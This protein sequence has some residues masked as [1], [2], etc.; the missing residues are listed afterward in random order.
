MNDLSLQG[1]CQ[2]KFISGICSKTI[3]S[4]LVIN[5]DTNMI[6]PAHRY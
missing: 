4:V 2:Q 1:A 3:A 5:K 6:M